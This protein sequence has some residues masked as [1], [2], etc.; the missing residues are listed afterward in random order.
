MR[1]DLSPRIRRS[2]RP[3]RLAKRKAEARAAK[4]TLRLEA[5]AIAQLD[6]IAER[7]GMTRD[8]AAR[9]LLCRGLDALAL[10]ASRR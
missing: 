5:P 8:D 7:R 4:V 10:A 6:A 2:V 9:D 3:K 1:D